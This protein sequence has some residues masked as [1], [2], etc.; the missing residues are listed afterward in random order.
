MTLL[1]TLARKLGYIPE[2]EKVVETVIKAPSTTT[3]HLNCAWC[4]NGF[5]WKGHPLDNHPLFCSTGHRKANAD[6]RSNR[7]DKMKRLKEKEEEALLDMNTVGRCPTPYKQVHRNYG[8]AREVI[9]RVDPS[10]EP[11]KCVCGGIHVGHSKR[12]R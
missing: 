8:A 12:K 9:A 6:A 3:R 11:Y 1:D 10:M 4:G 5:T 2:S 7:A